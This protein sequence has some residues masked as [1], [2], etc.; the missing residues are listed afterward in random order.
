MNE[1]FHK[2]NMSGKG[3]TEYLDAMENTKFRHLLKFTEMYI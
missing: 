1:I 2:K 3:D